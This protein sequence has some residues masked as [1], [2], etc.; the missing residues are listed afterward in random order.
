MQE[1]WVQSLGWE[2]PLEKVKATHSN[3]LA[4]RIPC[5]VH[6]IAESDMTEQLSLLHRALFQRPDMSCYLILPLLFKEVKEI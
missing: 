1:T 4:C 6:E 5:I 3:I 2:D